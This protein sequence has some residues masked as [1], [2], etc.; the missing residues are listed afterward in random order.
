MRLYGFE[1]AGKDGVHPEAVVRSVCSHDVRLG[2]VGLSRV[3]AMKS[4][5]MAA[6]MA[7]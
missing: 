7:E 1:S 3:A 6:V 5:R 2:V 4:S